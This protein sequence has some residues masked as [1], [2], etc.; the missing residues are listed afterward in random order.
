MT[1]AKLVPYCARDAS[2]V[3][4]NDGTTGSAISD[5]LRLA[6]P[7]HGLHARVDGTVRVADP[8]GNQHTIQ[9]VAGTDY[10]RTIAQV[11]ATGTTLTA[12]EFALL[13]G[14]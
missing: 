4:R 13:W 1:L 11:F 9:C 7:A 8:Y 3:L 14:V 12:S 5:T 2:S 6:A 10:P